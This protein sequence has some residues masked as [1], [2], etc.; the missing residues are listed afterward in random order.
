MAEIPRLIGKFHGAVVGHDNCSENRV[1]KEVA[2]VGQTL[3]ALSEVTG[4][5]RP[6]DVAIL[7][8]WETI[9]PSK[10]HKDSG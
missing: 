7:Y 10:M 3:E 8:D 9:G 1:F 4:T 6:A 5:I 2:K